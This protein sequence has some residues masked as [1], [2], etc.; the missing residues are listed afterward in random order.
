MAETANVTANEVRKTRGNGIW[1]KQRIMDKLAEMGSEFDPSDKVDKLREQ[2]AKA[3][4]AE[5]IGPEGQSWMGQGS[6]CW[7]SKAGCSGKSGML[8]PWRSE[9]LVIRDGATCS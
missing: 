5:E 2:L 7:E 6:E 4:E 9:M 1:R 3:I 8:S